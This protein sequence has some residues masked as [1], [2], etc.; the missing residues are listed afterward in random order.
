[1]CKFYLKGD[2]MDKNIYFSTV[3]LAALSFTACS[4][5]SSNSGAKT[6][7]STYVSNSTKC[8]GG[9]E[10]VQGYKLP[11]CPDEKENAK[12]LLGIDT[13]NNGVRDDVEVWIYHTYDT[14][15]PCVEENITVTSNN[16]TLI[17]GFKD[18]CEDKRVPYHQIV[19]EV[20]MQ[21]ARAYQIV[22]QE[23]EKARENKKYQDGAQQCKWYFQDYAKYNNEPLLVPDKYDFYK[24]L[25]NVQFNTIQRVRAYHEFNFHLGGGVYR[26]ETDTQK[27]RA[28]CDFDID[29]TLGE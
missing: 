27:L 25:D 10:V 3:L 15:I 23:P 9:D 22:I 2:K 6:T 29:K 20:A 26:L 16:G 13:N 4:N 7:P 19:R 11:P 8:T 21:Y 14:Y 18:V 5:S 28:A 1:M 17:H 12:T 24:E